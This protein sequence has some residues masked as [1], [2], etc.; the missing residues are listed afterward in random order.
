MKCGV[1]KYLVAWVTYNIMTNGLRKHWQIEKASDLKLD[2]EEKGVGPRV[3]YI[4]C[5]DVWFR[6]I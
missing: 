4:Q 3:I 1:S 5:T 2:M 6:Q